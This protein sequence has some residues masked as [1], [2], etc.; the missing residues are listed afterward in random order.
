MLDSQ[1]NLRIAESPTFIVRG[2]RD[3]GQAIQETADKYRPDLLFVHR[4]AEAMSL[5][6]RRA[7][8]PFSERC[9]VRVVP[10]RMT[11]AWLL[12]D[13]GAIRSAASNPNG[14]SSLDLPRASHLESLTDPKETLKE[15]IL[16]ASELSN[17]RRQKLKR[18][19]SRRVHTVAKAIDDFSVLRKL[20]S[21]QAFED[22][23]MAAMAEL[24]A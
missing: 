12:I 15:T 1:P 10:V 17:R 14:R 24:Q 19:L 9:V 6:A 13:E 4:D 22:D 18:S 7:E 23:L 5:Q 11:E 16:T 21:F 2:S 8:I 20:Q 3:M